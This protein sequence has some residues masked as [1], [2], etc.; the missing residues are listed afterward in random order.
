MTSL[1]AAMRQYFPSFLVGQFEVTLAIARSAPDATDLIDALRE[2]NQDHPVGWF[3]VSIIQ[4]AA[5]ADGQGTLSDMLVSLFE[6]AGDV[7]AHEGQDVAAIEQ[8]L[9]ALELLEGALKVLVSEE[10]RRE[11]EVGLRLLQPGVALF[12]GLGGRHGGQRRARGEQAGER[13][14]E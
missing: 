7:E 8:A 13:S 5:V 10:R 1:A 6:A 14:G 9:G 4:S 2:K 3:G 11:V 12:G